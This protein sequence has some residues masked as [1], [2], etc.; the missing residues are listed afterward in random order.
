MEKCVCVYKDIYTERW[1]SVKKLKVAEFERSL[2]SMYYS[3]YLFKFFPKNYLR[4]IFLKTKIY[5][6]S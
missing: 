2:Y 1:D 3:T 4:N 5:N 6:T